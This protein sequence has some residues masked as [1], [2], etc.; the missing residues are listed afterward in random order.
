MTV[1]DQDTFAA[2]LLALREAAGLTKNALAVKA[3]VSP[4]EIT[5]YEQGLKRPTL[6][7]AAKL[8]EAL[9]VSLAE[10]DELEWGR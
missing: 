9:G 7:T 5:R 6:Q 8:T 10:F 4:I 3:G 1:P 2:R